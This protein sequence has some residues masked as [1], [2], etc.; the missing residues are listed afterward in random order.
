MIIELTVDVPGLGPPGSVVVADRAS[1]PRPGDWVVVVDDRV[2]FCCW[3][4]G[5]VWAAVVVSVLHQ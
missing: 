5:V 4:P 1:V 3:V 2:G